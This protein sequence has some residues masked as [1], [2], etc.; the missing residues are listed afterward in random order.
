MNDNSNIKICYPR[1]REVKNRE[2]KIEKDIYTI[3]F[4]ENNVI[5]V[6]SKDINYKLD[7]NQVRKIFKYLV[8]IMLTNPKENRISATY[9]I[10]NTLVETK[11]SLTEEDKENF[12]LG[13]W[14]YNYLKFSEKQNLDLFDIREEYYDELFKFKRIENEIKVFGEFGYSETNPIQVSNIYAI[15]DYFSKLRTKSGKKIKWERIESCGFG[16]FNGSTD[17]YLIKYRKNL[18]KQE[19]IILYINIYN[20]TNSTEAPKGF[21]IQNS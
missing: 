11:K 14:A 12:I 21:F 13:V 18:L 15:N 19:T 7:N 17:K 4:D 5:E 20:V 3:R 10:L 9:G 1:N 16:E 2:S 8:S 6:I